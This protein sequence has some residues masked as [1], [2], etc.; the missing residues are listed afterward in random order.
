[1]DNSL[2][3]LFILFFAFTFA[4]GV[5]EISEGNIPKAQSSVKGWLS[6]KKSKLVTNTE[7]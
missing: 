1:M 7:Q 6:A 2:N 3:C 4:D 5:S